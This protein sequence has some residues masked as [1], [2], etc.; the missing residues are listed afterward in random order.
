MWVDKS[1]GTTNSNLHVAITPDEKAY[2]ENVVEEKRKYYNQRKRQNQRVLKE[3]A[4]DQ[5]KDMNLSDCDRFLNDPEIE[6]R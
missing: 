4:I 3:K 5:M 1:S 2:V 6:N